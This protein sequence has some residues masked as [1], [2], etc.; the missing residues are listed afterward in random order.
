MPHPLQTQLV[1]GTLQSPPLLTS[2]SAEIPGTSS[3]RHNHATSQLIP[4]KLEISPGG[5]E[6][7][8]TPIDTTRIGNTGARENFQEKN[9]IVKLC[10][11]WRSCALELWNDAWLSISFC[12][13]PVVLAVEIRVDSGNGCRELRGKRV[14]NIIRNLRNIYIQNIQAKH[15]YR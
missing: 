3:R 13:R 10:G 9:Y 1:K 7:G 8:L 2:F 4:K 6:V 11:F 15:T 12:G 14:P 5:M